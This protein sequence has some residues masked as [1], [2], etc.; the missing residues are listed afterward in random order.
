MQAVRR[1][2]TAVIFFFYFSVMKKI[3]ILDEVKQHH[4]PLRIYIY[5]TNL[6]L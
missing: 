3:Y 2:T 5:Q 1:V 6:L 4:F